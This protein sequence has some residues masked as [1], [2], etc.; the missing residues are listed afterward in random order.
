MADTGAVRQQRYHRHKMGDHSMCK[1]GC[2][3]GQLRIAEVPDGGGES[4]DPVAEL[5]QLAVQ[6]LAAYRADPGNA[7]LAKEC[8]ATLLC[9]PGSQ[10]TSQEDAQ[11]QAL[12]SE[13]SRPYRA[14]DDDS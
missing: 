1:R 4:L 3:R 12:M 7:A 10:G 6:L 13:L 8:R 11:W 14:G 2:Q 5:R 9:V